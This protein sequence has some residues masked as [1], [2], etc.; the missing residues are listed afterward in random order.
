[1]FAQAWDFIVTQPEKYWPVV[2]QHI[3]VSAIAILISVVVSVCLGV[4]CAKNAR[5]AGSMMAVANTLRLIPSLAVLAAAL[6]ILG[7][8]V[9][10]AVIALVVM[11]CPPMIINIYLGF[12][13]IDPYVIECARSVGM[14]ARQVFF[15]VELPLA[16]PLILSGV[17]TAVVEVVACAT[18]ASFIGAGGLGTF[19]V[20]GLAMNDYKYLVLGGVSVA[21]LSTFG[22]VTL[23]LVQRAATRYQRG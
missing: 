14:N 19:I 8:G 13:T 9:A 7:V 16:V 21:I 11:A 20:K 17:R 15:R 12:T 1:M 2:L 23:G 18:L 5:M 10:P 3:R 4:L 6:P 22:E